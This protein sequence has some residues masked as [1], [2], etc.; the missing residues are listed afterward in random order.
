MRQGLGTHR[1]VLSPESLTQC[2]AAS[3]FSQLRVKSP[4]QSS[5]YTARLRP[6][7]QRLGWRCCEIWPTYNPANSPSGSSQFTRNFLRLL[8]TRFDLLSARA[9]AARAQVARA[10]AAK[11]QTDNTRQLWAIGW[12][13]LASP[14]N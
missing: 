9:Q 13:T 10:Q 4:I 5:L 11:A 6:D 7:A 8:P 2:P 3:C 12:Q 1:S 14:G